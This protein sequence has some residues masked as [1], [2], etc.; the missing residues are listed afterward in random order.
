MIVIIKKSKKSKANVLP[1]TKSRCRTNE[2]AD[3]SDWEIRR[4]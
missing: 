3:Y 2:P 4:S 1:T